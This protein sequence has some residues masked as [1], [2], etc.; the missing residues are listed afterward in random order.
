MVHTTKIG[1]GRLAYSTGEVLLLTMSHAED[2]YNTL[3][4]PAFNYELFKD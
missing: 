3:L 4:L 1:F 2:F